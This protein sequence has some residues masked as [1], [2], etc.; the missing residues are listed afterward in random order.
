M[1]LAEEHVERGKQ[2]RGAVALVVVTA[3]AER[4]PVGQLAI[5]LGALQHL[6]VRLFVDRQDDGIL[7]RVEIEPDDLGG[8]GD[9]VRIIGLAP[10]LA[11]RQVDLLLARE[12]PDVL[13]RHVDQLPRQQRRGLANYVLSVALDMPCTPAHRW[14]RY[15]PPE[16]SPAATRP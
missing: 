11:R 4:S 7:R 3:T 2:G 8:L 13:I 16:P 9:E 15:V 1:D 10:R 14:A 6:D 5:A 12:A